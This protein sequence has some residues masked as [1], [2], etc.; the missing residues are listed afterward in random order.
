M[1][2]CARVHG[3][4]AGNPGG[5]EE[6]LPLPLLLLTRS[7]RLRLPR[8]PARVR[9]LS[10]GRRGLRPFGRHSRRAILGLQAP[11][12]HT[13]SAQRGASHAR[14]VNPSGPKWAHSHALVLAHHMRPRMRTA[15]SAHPDVY[16]RT[17]SCF[18]L[19]RT[20]LHQNCCTVAQRIATR[21][22]IP[23]CSRACRWRATR[24]QSAPMAA[25][26]MRTATAAARPAASR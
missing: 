11:L 18:A 21:Y 3:S 25:S 1:R 12:S 6:R 2:A 23:R 22:T 24:A 10:L 8:A 9:W 16:R 17:L 14:M 5:R 4:G 20:M 15:A 19:C 26:S 13:R 7:L